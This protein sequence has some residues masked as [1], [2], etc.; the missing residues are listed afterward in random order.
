[1]T[2]GSPFGFNSLS[3]EWST[4]LAQLSRVSV[5]GTGAPEQ[6][7]HGPAATARPSKAEALQERVTLVLVE[8][9]GQVLSVL[10]VL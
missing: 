5:T 10:C 1:M 9:H 6:V 3:P 4:S 8:K 2:L 7:R